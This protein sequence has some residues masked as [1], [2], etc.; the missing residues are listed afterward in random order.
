MDAAIVG[1]VGVVVGAILTAGFGLLRDR[2]E[3]AHQLRAELRN[4]RLAAIAA[5]LAADDALYRAQRSYSDY[6]RY[7]ERVERGGSPEA[8]AY[9]KATFAEIAQDKRAADREIGLT[10]SRLRLVAPDI[11]HRAQ[12][13]AES[14]RTFDVSGPPEQEKKR[15][16]ALRSFE[17]AAQ[18]SIGVETGDKE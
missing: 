8:K 5:F 12:E 1:L 17:A 3:R 15:H 7:Y 6:V 2:Q 16:T 10:L 9:A 18:R 11:R 13:L 14:S 4:E